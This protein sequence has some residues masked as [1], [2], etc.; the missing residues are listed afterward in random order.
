M[1]IVITNESGLNPAHIEHVKTLG[2]VE[3]YTDTDK[4]NIVERLAEA[5]IA[6][7][8]CYLTPITRELLKNLPSLKFLSTNSTGYDGVDVEALRQS[9][10]AASNVPGFSTEAV[11]EM[12]IALMFA[13]VRKIPEGDRE[14]RETQLVVD[15]GTPAAQKYLTFDLKG[16][17]LGVVGLG[18]IG[19]RVAEIGNGIGMNV[20]GFNR[21]NKSMPK[22]SLIDL[23]EVMR[24]SDVVIICLA[25]NAQTKGIITKQLIASMKKSAILVNIGGMSLLDQDALAAALNSG[26]IAGAALDTAGAELLAVKNTII[27]PHMAYNTQESYENM[28]AIIV[29]NIEAYLQ[30]SPINSL[31]Q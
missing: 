16:K 23:E 26:S 7:V 10:I 19:S 15:P 28:G 9:G 24:T 8:D 22:I 11:A 4:A 14:F 30:G 25:L 20:V 13:A 31:V 6:V 17:T 27:T 2:D 1:K 18:S 29:K 12:A 3:V 21:T 5:D